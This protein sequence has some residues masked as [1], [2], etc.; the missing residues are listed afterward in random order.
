MLISTALTIGMVTSMS[1]KTTPTRILVILLVVSFLSIPSFPPAEVQIVNNPIPAADEPL[2]I[3]LMIGDGMGFDHVEL[4]QLVEVGELGSLNMQDSDWNAT[5]TTR[6]ADNAI[7]DSAA[8]A[9]AMATGVKTT[10]GRVAEDPSATPLETI[11]EYAQ[12]QNKSTGV[13]STCR[14]VD[15]TPASFMV[16][17]DSRYNYAEMAQQIVEEAGVDVLLGGGLDYFDSGQLSTMV[18]NGYSVVYNMTDLAAVTS[19]KVF[20]LFN[21]YHMDY[22]Y[23]RDYAVQPSIAEMTNKSLEL[24]S[25]DS[26]GF[27]LMV[28]G[29]RIDLAAHDED[30]VRNALDTIAFDKAVEIAK[31]YVNDNNNTILIVTADHETEGL[32]V[33]SH[34]LNSELPG[35]LVAEEDRRTLR[36]QRANNVTVNWTA[37]YHTTWPVPVYTFGDAFSDMPEDI[38]IDNTDIYDLMKNY[39]MGIPLNETDLPTTTTTTSTTTTDTSSTT[40]TTSTTD[41]TSTTTS[42]DTTDTTTTTDSTTSPTGTPGFPIDSSTLLIVSIGSALIILIVVVMVKRR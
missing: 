14:I 15:A 24:L 22:E 10:N 35:D 21:G 11:L 37:P 25:Q 7:T 4:A 29:G 39:Y 38:T 16:H 5:M 32:V 3:I 6:N 23:D 1:A 9:T 8:A 18:S 31:D 30:Q 19:G 41:T 40:E 36:A 12:T 34:D 17:T 28:E 20:G 33:L 27:F 2:S 42:T 26:D 13:V